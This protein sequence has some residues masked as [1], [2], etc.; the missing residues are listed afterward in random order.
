MNNLSLLV[1][2]TGRGKKS[3]RTTEP[4]HSS[5]FI[6]VSRFLTVSLHT[7]EPHKESQQS[8]LKVRNFELT[9]IH[10][11]ID[12]TLTENVTE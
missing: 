8:M 12:V 11:P 4:E 3:A 1:I 5:I 7:T 2:T 9:A 10:T 6:E